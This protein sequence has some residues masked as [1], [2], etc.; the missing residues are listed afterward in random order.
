[1]PSRHLALLLAVLAL[2][3]GRVVNKGPTKEEVTAA[4]QNE[5]AG[6]KR[7]GEKMDPAL[8]VKAVWNISGVE[9]KE[10]A[11][12]SA[13][14]FTG[15]IRFRINS[16]MDEPTGPVETNFDKT[17]NYVYDAKLGKWLIKP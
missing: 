11:G 7:D 13:Q 1:M 6:M 16:R 15:A 12:N 17:F 4:L 9:V 2:C 10:Q 8:G 3:C 14:P 5:A